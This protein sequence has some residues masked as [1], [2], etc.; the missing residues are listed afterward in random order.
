MAMSGV[1]VDDGCM[2]AWAKLKKGHLKCAIFKLTDDKK[3]II[4]EE[5]T[6]LTAKRGE[7]S[8]EHFEQWQGLLPPENCRYSIYNMEISLKGSDD[9]VGRRDKLCF[10]T[11]AP[12]NAKIKEKMLTAASKDAL[13]KKLDGIALEFQCSS[14]SDIQATNFIERLQDV[15]NIKLAGVVTDF[16]GR[17][18]GD[19]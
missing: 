5:G 8:P 13:K 4:V 15:P 16:E 9:I 3:K 2:D 7:P 1:T 18:S 17:S 19:W 14:E 11:W 12:D 6:A 10:I